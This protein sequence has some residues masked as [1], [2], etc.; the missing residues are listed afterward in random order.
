M[1]R[2]STIIVASIAGVAA[3][4]AGSGPA[5]AADQELVVVN[6]VTLLDTGFADLVRTPDG[7]LFLSGGSGHDTLQIVDPDGV[8]VGAVP[9]QAG[10]TGLT[11]SA[12]GGTA[13]AA[14]AGAGAISAIDTA[15]GAERARYAV[16]TDTCPYDV[17]LAGGKLWFSYGCRTSSGHLGSIAL[18]DPAAPPVLDQGGYLNHPPRLESGPADGPLLFAM[19]EGVYP[20]RLLSYDVTGATAVRRTAVEELVQGVSEFAVTADG[21]TVIAATPGEYQFTTKLAAYSTAD[22]TELGRYGA[23][24]STVGL[25]IAPDGRIAT[26]SS[27]R[28]L[29]TFA[30]GSYTPDW[31]VY[32]DFAPGLDPAHRGLAIG[33]ADRLYVVSRSSG[34]TM[35]NLTTI[36]A[37]PSTDPVATALDFT[38]PTSTGRVG[39]PVV[40]AGTL[41]AAAGPPVGVQTLHVTRTDRRGSVTLPDV[42]TAADGSLRMRDKPRVPGETTWTFTFDGTDRLLPTTYAI[43][44]PVER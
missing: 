37:P 44:L 33:A 10:A 40:F 42:T 19:V 23:P 8:V 22:L 3:V 7:R 16:G 27:D 38:S 25:A 32:R 28:G 17:A 31:V 4:A 18:A 21:G 30:P 29:A 11:L 5:S 41:S 36:D 43:T 1:R 14:L 13:Y 39:R 2:L 9:G 12:D 26:Y 6:S 34:N 24:D 15:T 35:M 20:N